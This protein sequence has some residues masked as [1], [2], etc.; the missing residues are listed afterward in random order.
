MNNKLQEEFEVL[1]NKVLNI[2]DMSLDNNLIQII[3]RGVPH[4]PKGLPTGIMGIYTF[5]YNGVFL[6]IGRTGLKSNARFLS[7]HYNPKSAKSNLAK[8]ILNDENMKH[9]DL[10]ENNISEWIKMNCQRVDILISE[11]LGIFALELVEASLHFKYKPI[12]E[13]YSSQR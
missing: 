2:F 12:Y 1:I 3:D 6:K 8:S 5:Y 11:E 13:G 10:D 7:Q 4:T 9:L